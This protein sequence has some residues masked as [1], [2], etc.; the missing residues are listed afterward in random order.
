MWL[1]NIVCVQIRL[2]YGKGQYS[3]LKIA[4]QTIGIK[5]LMIHDVT[6]R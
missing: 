1:W 3:D 2:L 4:I 5:S 6:T